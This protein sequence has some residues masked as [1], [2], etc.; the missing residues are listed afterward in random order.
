MTILLPRP[1]AETADAVTF[2]KRDVE[3]LEEAIEDLEAR[4]AFVATHGEEAL[5]AEIVWRMC[6]GES[7]V[8]VFR[9]H[10]G[11]SATELASRAGVS[12]SCL[13]EI[14][15][16]RKPGSARMLGALARILGVQVDDL[17]C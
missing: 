12:P 3:T 10:R 2:R 14:E 7:P 8:R 5:P 15:S 16:G 17:I 13:S 11:L 6:A 9:E 1:I 4:A